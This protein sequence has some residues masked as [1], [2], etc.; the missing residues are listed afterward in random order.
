MGGGDGD[1]SSQRGRTRTCLTPIGRGACGPCPCYFWRAGLPSSPLLSCAVW[2]RRACGRASVP[3]QKRGRGRGG[4][5]SSDQ[6]REAGPGASARFFCRCT[7]RV[8]ETGSVRLH[9]PGGVGDAVAVASASQVPFCFCCLRPRPEATLQRSLV[10]G[11]L[12]FRQTIVSCN[13]FVA[14]LFSP[15]CLR[16]KITKKIQKAMIAV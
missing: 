9:A 7:A 12:V 15:L 6:S 16:T 10:I 11:F 8:T 13:V 3:G 5:V 4:G 1:W 14:I 2:S